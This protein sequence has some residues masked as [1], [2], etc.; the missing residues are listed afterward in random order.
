MSRYINRGRFGVRRNRVVLLESRSTGDLAADYREKATGKRLRRSLETTDLD[1]AKEK[2][3][4]IL[5]QQ[6]ASTPT[7]SHNGDTI[8]YVVQR[9]D[10]GPIKVGISRRLKN[11]VSQLQ[12][13][14]AEKL[15]VL[16]VYKMADV[17]RAVHGELERL[18]RLEGEWFPADLLLAVDRFFNVDFDTTRKRAR[19]KRD[20]ITAKAE[21]LM[22]AGLCSVDTITEV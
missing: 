20:E 19:I 1:V 11:R 7:T 13:G 6:N 16:R 2:I 9:G 17:E 12:N 15:R 3:A 18:A 22:S 8:L 14:S 21:Y 5:E 10:D 4:T